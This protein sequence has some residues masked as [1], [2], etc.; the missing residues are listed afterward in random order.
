MPATM[1]PFNLNPMPYTNKAYFCPTNPA[2][3]SF[4]SW[5]QYTIP[6]PAAAFSATTQFRWR[7]ISPT[8]QQWDFWGIENVNILLLLPVELHMFGLL[9]LALQ[10]QVRH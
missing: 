7:Q 9:L 8:S 3:Q 6:I 10:L 2:L 5:N 1:W 4:T